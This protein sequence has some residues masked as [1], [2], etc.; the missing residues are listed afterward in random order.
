MTVKISPKDIV[1]GHLRTLQ[2]DSTGRV[3]LIDWLVF[4]GLPIAAGIAVW[5][6]G[7]MVTNEVFNGSASVFGIFVGLL[8][9]V[10]VAIFGI[11]LRKPEKS[12]DAAAQILVEI[13]L[14]RRGSAL[15]EL[16]SNI[17]YLILICSIAIGLCM[18]FLGLSH[19]SPWITGTITLFYTHILLNMMMTVK[20]AFLLFD[21]EYQSP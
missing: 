6:S 7:Q 17:A 15:R 21:A 11:F 16:N 5:Y 12:E 13:Q 8:L 10:Q 4:Y 14:A 2:N 19:N 9:N 3:S 1:V 20:R 18:I